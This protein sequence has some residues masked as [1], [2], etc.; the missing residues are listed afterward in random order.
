MSDL[1]QVYMDILGGNFESALDPQNVY[2][3]NHIA[4]CALQDEN[5]V[6]LDDVE[7]VLRR[8]NAL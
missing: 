1:R 4:T 8:R 2:L 3:M 7:L 5:N 6:R